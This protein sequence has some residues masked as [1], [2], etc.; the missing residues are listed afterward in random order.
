MESKNNPGSNKKKSNDK[1]K[2]KNIE[3]EKIQILIFEKNPHEYTLY[4]LDL[5]YK[6]KE[7]NFKLFEKNIKSIKKKNK[8]NN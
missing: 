1:D 2:F 4:L 3:E 5:L 8:F 6:T 7:I